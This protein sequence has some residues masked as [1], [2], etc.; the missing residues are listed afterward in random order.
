MQQR[1]KLNRLFV[2]FIL[3]ENRPHNFWTQFDNSD[4]Y[5]CLSVTTIS[6]NI[7]F[8]I[9]TQILEIPPLFFSF[10]G[11]FHFPEIDWQ[12]YYILVKTFEKG[13]VVRFVFKTG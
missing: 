3:I 13:V 8:Q 12:P 2:Y 5:V 6:Y 11:R 7:D 1:N 10:V 4:L 9:D